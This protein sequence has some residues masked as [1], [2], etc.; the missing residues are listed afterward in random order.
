[1]KEI[2]LNIYKKKSIKVFAIVDDADYEYLSQWTWITMKSSTRMYAGRWELLEGGKKKLVLMHR[3]ILNTPSGLVTD[4][5]DGN[6]LNNQT[7]NLR[8]ATVSQNAAN[9][10]AH[11]NSTSKY[12]GIYWDKNRSKW[13][14]TIRKNKKDTFLGRFK[15][16]KDAA[17]AYNKAASELHGEFARLNQVC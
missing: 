6:G 16:E 2:K 11:K 14:A 8:Q 13:F 9:I 5:K 4:H 3:V 15:E 17:L 7:V 12:L 1:M 10:S